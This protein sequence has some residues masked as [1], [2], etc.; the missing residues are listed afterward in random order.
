[1]R[2]LVSVLALAI[3]LI[4]PAIFISACGSSGDGP[5]AVIPPPP[6]VDTTPKS[7]TIVSFAVIGTMAM[8]VGDS[9]AA[10]QVEATLSNGTKQA[11]SSST[12]VL[13]STAPSVVALTAT[14]MKA[15]SPGTAQVTATYPGFTV[16][17][18]SVVVTPRPV[19]VLST[20]I[21]GDT[22]TEAPRKVQLRLVRKYSDGT[23]KDLV[24]AWTYPN[25]DYLFGEV[26]PTGV[27]S[28]NGLGVVHVY[29]SYEGV[30]YSHQVRIDGTPRS[31]LTSVSDASWVL[32]KS[33][34]ARNS[35]GNIVVWRLK[36]GVTKVWANSAIPW[37]NVVDGLDILVNTIKGGKF[38][39]TFVGDSASSDVWLS[40]EGPTTPAPTVDHCGLAGGVI[41]DNTWSK[42]FIWLKPTCVDKITIAHEMTH[43]IG[44]RNHT[45]PN[46]DI[47]SPPGVWSMSKDLADA[48]NLIMS[49]QPGTILIDG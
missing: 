3:A 9:V 17:P 1:M 11:V 20:E 40:F 22:T 47:L 6:P 21:V 49:L 2:R 30:Q 36:D 26:S 38:S 39:Y 41:I 48:L 45:L 25:L 4:A 31:K 34:S 13:G 43:I 23:E 16:T 46:T 24:A 42:G 7:P 18:L 44:P 14:S 15:V 35:L 27:V 37:Q 32:V 8:V 28:T 33:A 12:I 5:V 29:A 10:P 19:T